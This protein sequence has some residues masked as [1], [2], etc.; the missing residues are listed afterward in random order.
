M[1]YNLINILPTWVMEL[2]FPDP[3]SFIPY[4][5]D[6]TYRDL[7]SFVS[8]ETD[9]LDREPF[10]SIRELILEH[11]QIIIDECGYEG[12]VGS[13]ITQSWAIKA[14]GGNNTPPHV[15]P[16]SQFSGVC[17]FNDS[18]H[19]LV[20]CREDM[21]YDDKMPI[22][23]FDC[24][25]EHLFFQN[26]HNQFRYEPKAGKIL[27]FPSTMKHYVEMIPREVTETRYS[28]AFN[29]FLTGKVLTDSTL[30]SIIL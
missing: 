17:Y 7:N 23:V 21:W 3:G 16:N 28:L 25:N 2:E 11:L 6:L 4:F 15:H 13:R 29:T 9:I 24:I 5:D 8:H 20:L 27:I 18:P 22:R 26:T 10:T 1:T 30:A 19:A 12:D 14:T